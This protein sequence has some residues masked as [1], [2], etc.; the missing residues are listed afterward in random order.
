MKTHQKYFHITDQ[1][2]CALLPAFITVANIE[3]QQPSEVIAGNERV[4]RPRLSDAAFFFAND[5]QTAMS[6]RRDRLSSVI[7]QRE[8]GSL[9]DKTQRMETLAGLLAEATNADSDITTRAAALAK[10]Y[11]V[12]EMVLEFPELQ[13][14]AGAHYARHYGEPDRV[15]NAI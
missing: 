8:L 7:F 12:S 6:S 5:K 10:C 1:K 4:I 9:L 13:G 3:S 14:V 11:L 15:A 2:T